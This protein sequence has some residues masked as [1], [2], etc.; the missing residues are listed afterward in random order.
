M[1]VRGCMV[2]CVCVHS[3]VDLGSFTQAPEK[4]NVLDYLPYPSPLLKHTHTFL[5]THWGQS[6]GLEYNR[7]LPCTFSCLSVCHF[8]CHVVCLFVCL[9]ISPFL[10]SYT[11]SI[12][13]SPP[14][15][16]VLCD[17]SSKP[18]LLSSLSTSLSHLWSQGQ[19]LNPGCN[20]SRG[21]LRFTQARLGSETWQ[22]DKEIKQRGRW[23]ERDHERERARGREWGMDG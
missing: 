12:Y 23:R 16:S 7:W 9:F 11:P 14:T 5:M 8:V 2:A 13:P 22:R 18:F 15:H 4:Q 6:A 3:S 20:L 17:D 10:L 19:G 1:F 21:P